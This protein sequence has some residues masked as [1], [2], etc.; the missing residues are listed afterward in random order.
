MPAN[1]MPTP[2][3]TPLTPLS[4]LPTLLAHLHPVLNAGTWAICRLPPGA[5]LPAGLDPVVTVRE[6]E[7]RTLILP[8]ADAQDQRAAL[9]L[10]VLM[11]AAWLSLQVHS[12][13]A[14][15]GLT[16]AFSRVLADAGIACNV[17]AGACHDHVFVPVAEGGRAL[18]VLQALQQGAAAGVS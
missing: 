3:P 6:P 4:H 13:L 8:L 16:A 14:A 1:H 17:V 2:P 18:A 5:P 9:G 15:C 11:A 7:G 10:E 12:D